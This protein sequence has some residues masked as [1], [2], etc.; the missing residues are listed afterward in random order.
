MAEKSWQSISE[1][2]RLAIL[3]FEKDCSEA[4]V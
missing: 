3:G 2:D 1:L 4:I